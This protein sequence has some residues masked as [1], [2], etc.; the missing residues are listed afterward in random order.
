LLQP[1]TGCGLA[2]KARSRPKKCGEKTLNS[3][4]IWKRYPKKSVQEIGIVC[5]LIF[6]TMANKI[7]FIPLFAKALKCLTCIMFSNPTFSLNAILLWVK[8]LLRPVSMAF[9]LFLLGFSA[10]PCHAVAID[11]PMGFDAD[12]DGVVD[13]AEIA[14]GTD[15]NDPCSFVYGNQTETTSASWNVLDCDNDGLTNIQ[16]LQ[17]GTNPLNA[18]TDGDGVPDGVEFGDFSS[19]LNPCSFELLSQSLP[20]APAWFNLD[21]DGDWLT[22]GEELAAGTLLLNPDTDGDGV[23]DGTEMNDGTDPLNPCSYLAIHQ[24]ILPPTTAWAQLDCDSDGLS[25]S[26]ELSMGT[27]PQNP[28]TDGDGVSDGQEG[29]DGSN[30]LDPCS[31]VLASQ[32]LPPSAEWNQLDCD[33]DSTSNGQELALGSDPLNP[34]EPVPIDPNCPNI[35]NVPEAFSPNGD[36]FNDLYVIQGLMEFPNHSLKIYTRWGA[37]VFQAAPYLNDW[38][39]TAGEG[40]LPLGEELPTGT[41]YFILDLG[42]GTD[43]L[44]G[45]IYLNR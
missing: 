22:N 21:C 19:P 45:Y 32:T 11:S 27:D 34:C 33:A 16:E 3:R 4:R 40:T 29:P 1:A 6:S 35:F 14:D 12:G 8:A 36:G 2:L 44:T 7:K 9:A 13:S 28:D 37:L 30:P 5:L 41:Y 39:G 18:D 31:F 20:P 23:V 24:N 10:M 15:P 26:T 42:N 25:N 43:P 17:L 38:N